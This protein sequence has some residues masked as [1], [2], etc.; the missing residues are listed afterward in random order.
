MLDTSLARLRAAIDA[1]A[2]SADITSLDTE[3]LDVW[4]ERLRQSG[5]FRDVPLSS[6]AADVL[7]ETLP[8]AS[9]TSERLAQLRS[10]RERERAQVRAARGLEA[11]CHAQSPPELFRQLRERAGL[12]TEHAARL[13]G[14]PTADWAAVETKTKPWYQLGVDR[15]LLFAAAVHEPL[16]RFG[17]LLALTARRAVC[18][19][20]ESRARFALGRFDQQQ[21]VQDARRDSLRL[22]FAAVQ[23]ENAGAAKFLA[24]YRRVAPELTRADAA[25]ARPRSDGTDC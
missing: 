2:T 1:V 3:R 15:V 24:A 18:Q 21:A 14:V 12:T 20:V 9:V 19:S 6:G 5:L 13:S 17:D 23:Q 22:A 25:A 10:V 4:F 11:A 7:A 8:D 16:D